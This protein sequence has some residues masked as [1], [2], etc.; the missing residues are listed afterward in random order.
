RAGMAFAELARHHAASY[1]LG[2]AEQA[3]G[4]GDSRSILANLLGQ[5]FLR[6]AV[7]LDEAIEGFG[8][9]DGVEIFPLDVLDQGKLEGVGGG[10]VAD[11]DEYLF[12]A[13]ALRCAPTTLAGD[14]LEQVVF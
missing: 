3:Q 12:E 11:D 6:V 14:D 4:I 8:E 2:Q 13:G 7:F 10:N 5:R 9:L 1:L